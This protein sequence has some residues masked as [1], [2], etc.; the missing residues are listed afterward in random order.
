MR[1]VIIAI[2]VFAIHTG[3]GGGLGRETAAL[4]LLCPGT[5]VC[6]PAFPTTTAPLP[7]AT[8][9]EDDD[10]RA[11]GAPGSGRGLGGGGVGRM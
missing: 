9:E 6:P 5:P 2:C 4:I 11:P 8:A 10:A 7:A 1:M 3:F